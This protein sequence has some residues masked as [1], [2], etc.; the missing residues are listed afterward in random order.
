MSLINY[1]TFYNMGDTYPDKKII[2]GKYE[3]YGVFG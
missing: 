3:G 1:S 2:Y